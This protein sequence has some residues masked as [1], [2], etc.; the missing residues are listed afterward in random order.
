[1]EHQYHT[2]EITEIRQETPDAVSLVFKVPDKLQAK[3]RFKAGQYLMLQIPLNETNDIEERA[4]SI[5]SSPLE[6]NIA[7]TI[8]YAGEPELSRYL[9]EEIKVGDNLEVSEPEGR[10][11]IE[12]SDET[13]RCFYM[14]AAGS[15]ITPLMSILKTIL[16]EEPKST[17]HLLYGNRNHESVIFSDELSALEQRYAGQLIIEYMYTKPESNSGFLKNLFTKSSIE[18][19]EAKGRIDIKAAGQLLKKYPCYATTAEYFICGPGAM[20]S[21]LMNFLLDQNI[22]NEHIHV[23]HSHAHEDHSQDA[24]HTPDHAQLITHLYGET[25][26][27]PIYDK[28]VLETLQDAGYDPPYSCQS[29][30]CSTCMARIIEGTAE[31]EMCYA[32]DE[33]EIAEGFV[34]TCQ[35]HPTSDV[36][37]ITY[38]V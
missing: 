27:L 6:E 16:E 7:V 38:D 19:K 21:N 17:I 22:S 11:S 25:I 12:L 24:H 36:L 10:F 3:Y 34:L 9:N 5:S 18:G 29:G 13:E 8:K 30:A 20:I 14:F 28:T 31:M 15:G 33:D 26:T 1:M 37:E 23:E 35:A 4:Y 2:L 32:L